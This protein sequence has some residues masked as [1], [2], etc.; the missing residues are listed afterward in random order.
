MRRQITPENAVS[1]WGF[2]TVCFG[3][4][5]VK[6]PV[7][8]VVCVTQEE[9]LV[10]SCREACWGAACVAVFKWEGAQL[11]EG[12]SLW[13][14]K[15]LLKLRVFKYL[16]LVLCLWKSNSF[17]YWWWENLKDS[18][19]V[20]WF[21][22]YAL[23]KAHSCLR[24]I[25]KLCDATISKSYRCK[26]LE[27]A[28]LLLWSLYVAVPCGGH[29]FELSLYTVLCGLLLLLCCL[30]WFLPPFILYC[31]LKVGFNWLPTGLAWLLLLVKKKTSVFAGKSLWIEDFFVCLLSIS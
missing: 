3:E 7:V 29:R 25:W 8:S 26:A 28:L 18:L 30:H 20:F 31:S 5:A 14:S 23:W 4:V 6:C 27:N 13:W 9:F 17:T 1:Q 19:D 21:F 12:I 16:I 15:G 22:L 10:C 11:E 2:L 24:T